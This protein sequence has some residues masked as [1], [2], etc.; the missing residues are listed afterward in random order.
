MP[1]NLID[2]IE[3]VFRE[4]GATPN[5]PKRYD[6]FVPIIATRWADLKRKPVTKNFARQVADALQDYCPTCNAWLD[7]KAKGI[8]RPHVFDNPRP[9][10]WCLAN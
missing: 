3:D 7:A 10:Y 2:V 8:K 6:E 4:I 1:K 9:G 5:S